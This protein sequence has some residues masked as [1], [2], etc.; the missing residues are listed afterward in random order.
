M[1]INIVSL[2]KIWKTKIVRYAM[3]KFTV[4]LEKAARCAECILR[5]KAG[6]FAQRYA[7]KN[8]LTFTKNNHEKNI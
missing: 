5:I 2:E 1:H 3:K 4:N 8:I 6:N 7:E